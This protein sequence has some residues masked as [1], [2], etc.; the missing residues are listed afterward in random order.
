MKALRVLIALLL[1][2]SVSY[3]QTKEE[4]QKQK[5][6]LQDQID[7]ASTLL[8]QTQSNR[9]TS[10]NQLQTLNQKIE[11]RERLI[12]TM[13]RQIRNI[14]R[15]VKAKEQEIVELEVRIDS[16]KA[17]YAK[18]IELAQRNLQPADQLMFILSSSSFTQALKRIQYFK[19]MTGYR[20]RQVKQIEGAQVELAQ[21]K[22][23][24]IAK[25]AEKLNVQ[26]AQE[27][28]KNELLVDAQAQEKTVATLQSKESELKKDIQ[29]KQREAQQLEK[30]IK[31]IIAEEMRKAK[32]RAERMALEKEAEDLGL[33]KG[34]DFNPRTSN[35]V[36][37]RL[38]DKARAEKG[39]EVRDDGPS[40]AMFRCLARSPNRKPN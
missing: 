16:L 30:Q 5:V 17:D 28:E 4:L 12:T 6:L 39:L 2:A 21:E 3:G 1:F 10:L 33:V 13:N 8:K 11:A 23:A 25:K 35:K 18:L 29:K 31:R 40:Y 7:L 20:E 9:A 37:K 15:E 27:N 32:L 19:D 14:D 38:I 36:L 22:E 34:K 24:L 26:K